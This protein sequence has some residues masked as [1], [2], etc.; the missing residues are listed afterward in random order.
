MIALLKI[1]EE[2]KEKTGPHTMRE[3]G[4]KEEGRLKRKERIGA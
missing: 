3:P 2:E 4:T 1:R